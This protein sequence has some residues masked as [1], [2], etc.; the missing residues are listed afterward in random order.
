MSD[1]CQSV[2]KEYICTHVRTHSYTLLLSLLFC[3]LFPFLTNPPALHSDVFSWRRK[4]L[5]VLHCT[6]ATVW[7]T[8]TVC[9]WCVVPGVWSSESLWHSK[10]LEVCLTAGCNAW[11]SISPLLRECPLCASF[12]AWW[13]KSVNYAL[14]LVPL[15]VLNWGLAL[16]HQHSKLEGSNHCCHKRTVNLR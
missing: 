15:S 11:W 3:C 4:T 7:K 9:W 8:P 5:L 6:Y 1:P 14:F 13:Y 10:L 12:F 2:S 16:K